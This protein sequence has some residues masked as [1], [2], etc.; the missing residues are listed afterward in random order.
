[1]LRALLA[2]GVY[3]LRRAV[4]AQGVPI[5]LMGVRFRVGFRSNV[6]FRRTRTFPGREADYIFA[7][8]NAARSAN[9]FYDIGAN[10]GLFSLSAALLH[11]QLRVFAFEPE[12]LNYERLVANI[13]RNSLGARIT[14]LQTALGAQPGEVLLERQGAHSGLGGHAVLARDQESAQAVESVPCHRVDDLVAEGQLPPPNLVKIDVEGFE[15]Q[16]LRGMRNVL[17]EH[18]PLVFLELHPR[19]LSRFG[20]SPEDF[21]EFLAASDYRSVPL[22][23]S[24]MS[25]QSAHKQQHVVLRPLDG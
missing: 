14:P 3:Y 16:V 17:A 15:L 22:T 23:I 11:H 2:R 6:E 24:R 5:E 1:M 8:M 7:L 19:R 12:S 4:H 18:R 20:G 25:E 21:H 13:R 10:V 9:I